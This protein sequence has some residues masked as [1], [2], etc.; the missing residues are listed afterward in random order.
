ERVQ[1]GELAVELLCGEDGDTAEAAWHM[2]YDVGWTHFQQGHPDL[3][4]TAFQE[5]LE[6]ASVTGDLRVRGVALRNLA[7]VSREYDRAFDTAQGLYQEALDI[8]QQIGDAR[9]EAICKGGLGVLALIRGDLAQAKQNLSDAKTINEQLG[10]IE[11]LVSN[12]SDLAQLAL[13]EERLGQA[14]RLLGRSRRLAK[15]H[16]LPEEEAYAKVWLARLRERQGQIED[17]CDLAH[18]A[19][20]IYQRVGLQ[21]PFVAHVERLKARLQAVREYE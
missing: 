6:L 19:H 18:Q 9:W 7:Q 20:E 12:I 16:E 21:T 17:A 11:G 1:W 15:E 2:V 5:G 3:A 4:K 13:A 10:E 8:F 14:E